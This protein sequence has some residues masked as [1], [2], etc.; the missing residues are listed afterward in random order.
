MDP[1]TGRRVLVAEDRAGRPNDFLSADTDPPSEAASPEI[2]AACPFCVGNEAKTPQA[3]WEEV[4][5]RG[6]WQ[7]RLVPNKFPALTAEAEP[8]APLALEWPLASPQQSL[9]VHEVIV[10]SREHLAQLT[11]IS[12][13]Q[14][15]TVLQV[16]RRRLRQLSENAQ[17]RHGMI[18]KNVGA[19][20]GA[21]LRHLHSQLVALPQVPPVVEQELS[22]AAKLFQQGEGCAYCRLVEAEIAEGQR[23]VSANA[24]FAAICAYAGRQPFEMLILPRRHYAD[25]SQLVETQATSLAALLLECLQRLRTQLTGLAYNLILHTAPFHQRDSPSYHWHWELVPRSSYLAGF[26]WGTGL[27]INPL[28]PERAARLLREAKI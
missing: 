24:E 16:Y 19:Q 21:S 14:L 1:L 11:S 6:N 9:G 10:E 2:V 3:I 7:V 28:A 27:Y 5:H 26:E 18:F 15:A 17:L 4:D 12:V 20:A 8:S 13:G 25:Y 23:L 22:F